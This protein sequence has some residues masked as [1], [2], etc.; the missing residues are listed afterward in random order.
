MAGVM[1]QLD[2]DVGEQVAPG[3]VVVRLADTS[4]WQIETDDLTELDVVD[5]QVGAPVEITFD[6]MPDLELTGTVERIKA[7]GE[8]KLGDMTYTVIIRP[9]RLDDRMRWNMTATVTI[10]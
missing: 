6:A 7:I 5:V 10:E 4:Q 2:A 8:N 1:A 9:D 3:Q